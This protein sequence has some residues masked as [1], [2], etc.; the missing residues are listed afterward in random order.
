MIGV[1]AMGKRPSAVEVLT[2][3]SFDQAIGK[4]GK[5]YLVEFYAPWCGHCKA[6]GKLL[7]LVHGTLFPLVGKVY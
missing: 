5:S 1:K 3:A 4:T 2:D 6:L 7:S